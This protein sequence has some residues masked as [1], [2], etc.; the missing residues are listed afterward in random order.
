[1]GSKGIV[2]ST[3]AMAVLLQ[4][5]IG[6]TIRVSLTP[7]PGGDRERRKW[8]SRR[9]SCRPWACAP[10]RRWWRPVPAAAAR[11]AR[12]SRNWRSR[13]SPTCAA[14]AAVA[15]R[16]RRRR[17]HDAGGHG[18]RGQWPGREQARQHRHQ[19]A[20]HRRDAGGAGL[21][22]G[23]KTVT[24]RATTSPRSSRRSSTITWRALTRAG[25]H[26]D[27]CNEPDDSSDARDE[28]HPARRSRAV[29]AFRG[30]RARSWLRAYGYRPIRMPVVEPT[31]LFK[32]AIGEVTDIVE[33]EMYS[34]VDSLNGEQLTLRPE[35]TASCVRAVISAQPAARP[36]RLWY[37]GPMFRHEKPQ[38]GRYRQFHQ[39]G[40][41]AIGFRGPGRRCRA[42][43]DGGAAVGR[44][45]RSTASE[46]AD[47]LARQPSER[48]APTAP[49]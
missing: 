12:F 42:D 20:R 17:E 19:P 11:R 32:R 3:A 47:Q 36:Q 18:L 46:P 26:A 23:E 35:G 48:A 13:S 31:P 14:D 41:E 15:Q 30:C 44:P 22:D 7:E 5:G 2:A 24:L 8:W 39:V 29:G 10:S 34:F 49:S 38:K 45:R 16:A 1:M 28:R 9:R 25:K 27:F 37:M 33:K 40:V 4:E 6:D 21:F 43:R